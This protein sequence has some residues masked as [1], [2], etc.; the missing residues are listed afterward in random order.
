M[1]APTHT[2]LMWLGTAPVMCIFSQEGGKRPANHMC[3]NTIAKP[4]EPAAPAWRL[5][6]SEDCHWEC[7]NMVTP[8]WFWRK[9][10]QQCI[11]SLAWEFIV[12]W[13]W[14]LE[15]P[16]VRLM[17]RLRNVL[18]GAMT[19]H[20]NCRVPMR[21]CNCWSVHFFFLEKETRRSVHFWSLYAGSVACIVWESNNTPWAIS[22][23]SAL[24]GL[25]CAGINVWKCANCANMFEKMG[26]WKL[27]HPEYVIHL[28]LQICAPWPNAKHSLAYQISDMSLKVPLEG[29]CQNIIYFGIGILASWNLQET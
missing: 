13:W 28:E 11:S 12:M 25:Q 3:L 6:I 10:S 14:G 5:M 1:C 7:E 21:D 24:W 22:C 4:I 8:L 27:N 18:P 2:V 19:L 17:S 15:M 29:I 20:A 26:R 23:F 16:V 9:V